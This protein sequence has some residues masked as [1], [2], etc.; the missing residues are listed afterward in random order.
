MG[1]KPYTK[2]TMSATVVATLMGG[3]STIGEVGMAYN[4][5]M[6]YIVTLLFMPI[7]YV[8]MK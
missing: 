2:I 6:I 8:I 1:S 4:S 7:G 3:G 5:G